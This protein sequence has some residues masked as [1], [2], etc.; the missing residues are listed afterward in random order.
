MNETTD[1]SRVTDRAVTALFD[2]LQY[3]LDSR[4]LYGGL[5]EDERPAE[6]VLDEPTTVADTEDAP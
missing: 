2:T 4:D 3:R 6:G 1:P 5:P